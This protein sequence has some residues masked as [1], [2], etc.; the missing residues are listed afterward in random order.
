MRAGYQYYGL[1]LVLSGALANCANV[2]PISCTGFGDPNLAADEIA[3][4][5]LTT[6]SLEAIDG[7]IVPLGRDPENFVCSEAR[8]HPGSHT[9]TLRAEMPVS[10]LVDPT[11]YI[12]LKNDLLFRAEP[13]HSYELHFDRATNQDFGVSWWI[14]D[15]ETEEVVAGMSD[16]PPLTGPV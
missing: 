2:T 8:L 4:L 5:H 3:I 6:A 7:N 10:E 13:R 16:Q 1:L 12:S 11:G 15:A 14:V 9:L